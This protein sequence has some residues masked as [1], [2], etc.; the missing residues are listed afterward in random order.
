MVVFSRAMVDL[1]QATVILG[2]VTDDLGRA[3]EPHFRPKTAL[4][5]QKA[6]LE[7]RL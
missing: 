3:Q 7:S 4:F 6:R 1:F 2:R 5:G